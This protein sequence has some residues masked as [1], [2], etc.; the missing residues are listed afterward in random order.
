MAKAKPDKSILD[1]LTPMMRQ[2]RRVKAEFPDTI[3]FFRM[4]DFFEMFGEDAHIASQVL[5]IALTSRSKGP[6]A[7]PMAGVPHHACD[8]YLA[9]LVKAGH[10]VAICEQV[11]DPKTAKGVVKREVVRVITPGTVYE[12]NIV[13]S[14]ANVYVAALAESDSGVAF[15]YADVSTGELAC[16]FIERERLVAELNRLLPREILMPESE[17]VLDSLVRKEFASVNE[18]AIERTED[19]G[20]DVDAVAPE[21]AQH[22]GTDLHELTKKPWISA[23]C[24]LF[25]YLNRTQRGNL[26]Q[27]TAIRDADLHDVMLVDSRSLRDLEV[28]S[29][30]S[31]K[32]S[33]SLLGVTDFTVSALG[34]RSLRHWLSQPL[35]DIARIRRRQGAVSRFL[36][37]VSLREKVRETIKNMCD[38]ERVTAKA[39]TGRATPRDLA[40]LRDA[41]HLVNDLGE[42]LSRSAAPLSDT[43]ARLKAPQAVLNALTNSLV[44]APA[45]VGEGDVIKD[46]VDPEL[47]EIRRIQKG[48]KSWIAKYQR[49]ESQRTGIPNLKIGYNS[50][51]GYYIEVSNSQ[52]KNVPDD[53]TRKQTL[54]N[55]ERFITPELKEHES[56][57]FSATDRII[58]IEGRLFREL[59]ELVA[60]NARELYALAALVASIDVLS[61]FAVL[62]ET[63]RYCLPEVVEERN[64]TIRE[65]RHPVVE[66][67]MP[68]GSFVPNDTT[69][70]EDAFV[71]IIT[72]P[73]MAGKSTYIRQVAQIV[74]LAQAGAPVPA[75]SARIGIVDRLFTRIGASDDLARGR[76]TFMVEMLEAADILSF[77]T[78]R[79]LIILDE[80]G[81]GTSTFDGLSLAWA[82]TEYITDTRSCNARTLF[83]THYHELTGLAATRANVRNYQVVVR[84]SMG[85]IV[86]LHRIEPGSADRSYGIHVA[87]LAGLPTKVLGRAQDILRS[88]ERQSLDIEGKPKSISRRKGKNTDSAVQL[89]LFESPYEH[90]LDLIREADLNSMTPIEAFQ[91]LMELKKEL[92]S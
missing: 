31:G 63:R 36:E 64:M 24:G 90:L 54:V 14:D 47:D 28:L 2:Y 62:A 74:I 73:N 60:S 50:V 68:P 48:G 71:H 42:A 40:A 37:D 87:K 29:S 57:I 67:N 23:C 89:L 13:P 22:F 21:I 45:A 15:A 86:F 1:N 18:C 72:G 10:K 83:A 80:V 49:M 79:S 8:T 25:S 75:T 77:A 61:S 92:E 70:T 44:D 11:E 4:G 6:D 7:L 30:F 66:A 56:R 81:R 84:E 33:H 39:A 35:T 34:A 85:D 16:E 26:G 19:R 76:S 55:A 43:A 51:F 59:R 65:G 32:R 88:L 52:L 58:E 9:R 82:I 27:F 69:F 46:G 38:I 53:Y 91:L 12:E 78:P 3:L 17:T 20:W 5:G 41:L